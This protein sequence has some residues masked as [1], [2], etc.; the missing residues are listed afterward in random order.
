MNKMM[1]VAAMA[2]LPLVAVT[3]Q[4]M[5]DLK[6]FDGN[7]LMSL[8][9][10]ATREVTQD[11]LTATLQIE[12]NAKD[13]AEAQ[14]F[15]NTKMQAAQALA[16][17]VDGLKVSTGN[18]SVYKQYAPEPAPREGSKPWSPEQ[19]EKNASWQ[20]SQQLIVDGADKD[21]LL[22]L[23]A[24]LQK[25]GFAVQGLNYYLSREASDKLKDD[26][27]AE[28]LGTIKQ[29]ADKLAGVLGAKS[30]QYVWVDI[31]DGGGVMPQ[32]M[33]AR[34]MAFKGAAPEMDMAVPVAE[35]GESNVSVNVSAHVK[36]IK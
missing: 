13:A 3:A 12:K 34:A 7:T 32:P 14:R 19:R 9:A 6:D 36:L 4:P 23:V 33:M 35:A 21:S 31:N 25:D 29:R 10:Q 17:K 16:K 18:Y 24:S 28:A 11:R 30:V 5:P 1:F 22:K 27:A 15:I 26:L 8:S 2:A 20:A